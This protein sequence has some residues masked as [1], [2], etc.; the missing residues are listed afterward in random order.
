[1]LVDV[2]LSAWIRHVKIQFT[3]NKVFYRYNMTIY[4]D[5]EAP[6]ASFVES[7]YMV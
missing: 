1:M 6:N 2:C 3:I 4:G 7:Q 5:W